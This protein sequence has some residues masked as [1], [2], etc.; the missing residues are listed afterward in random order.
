MLDRLDAASVAVDALSVKSADLDDVFLSLTG[1]REAR[2][3]PP[4]TAYLVTDSA[5][6]LRRSLRRMRR[7][8]SLT[9]FIALIPVCPAAAVRVRAR[10]HDGRRAGRPAVASSRDAYIAYVLPGILLIT[11]AGAATGTAISVAMD[12]TDGII[13]RF[14]TMSIARASVLAGHVVGS[15]IQTV[16]APG[17]RVRRRAADRLPADD[18]ARSSGWPRSACYVLTSI[19]IVWLSVGMG[20]VTDSVETASNLPQILL[21]FAV[22]EQRVRPHGLDARAARVV[23]PEPA[24][25]PDH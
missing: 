7:Y 10:R 9:F 18:R 22:R 17:D 24:V 14:R 21:L 11:A 12:M 25:H 3:F 8:P 2:R 19:A 20:L 4:M 5:T 13:A 16:L 15:V 23:R 1:R 6:M